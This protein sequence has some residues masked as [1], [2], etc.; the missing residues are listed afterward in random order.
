MAPLDLRRL[1]ILIMVGV[2][3]DLAVSVAVVLIALK[4]ESASSSARIARISNYQ[5]CVN[6]N[7]SR[8]EVKQLWASIL[9]L[10]P[11]DPDAVVFK[12]NLITLVN[13]TY[14][15]RDCGKT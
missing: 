8:T 15:P 5:S 11:N 13:A 2:V 4:A 9:A 12:R 1:V 10:L 3:F 7:E 6:N 14:A